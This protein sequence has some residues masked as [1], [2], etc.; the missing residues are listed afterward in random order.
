MPRAPSLPRPRLPFR[1]GQRVQ[2]VCANGD[3][4]A[5]AFGTVIEIL[6]HGPTV[7]CRYIRVRDEAGG[8]E[9]TW[10]P[11]WWRKA[12][13]RQKDPQPAG[14]LPDQLSRP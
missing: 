4:K 14:P 6:Q 11:S 3:R 9:R 7:D 13:P 12:P 1:V 10:H 8:A 2:L 5:G